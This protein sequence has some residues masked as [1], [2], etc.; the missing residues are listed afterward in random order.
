MSPGL[1]FRSGRRIAG[2][3]TA[4]ASVGLLF[5][6]LASGCR[7]DAP[8]VAAVT[9]PPPATKPA[10]ISFP[11]GECRSCH[12]DI[13]KS[14]SGSHHALAHRVI[15][16]KVDPEAVNPA[17]N[18]TING[19]E[20]QLDWQDGRPVFKEIR[21]GQ[22]A[23]P[24][25]ADFVLGH[26]PLRQYIVPAGGGRYQ[27]AELAFDPVKKDWFNVFG[28]ERRL[29]GGMGTLA[30]ARHELELDVRA[31]PHD[32]FQQALRRRNR[33]VCL[34]LARARCRLHAVSRPPHEGAP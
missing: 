1:S 5:A 20:Y 31:L 12:E 9:P 27:A 25:T 28:D 6:S 32:R 10:P 2:L 8:K 21:P 23:E 3:V 18:T 30:R 29:P 7:P 19:I 11:S 17:R 24:Y 33:H 16:P 26:T 4:V 34:H 14:W 15:D 13:F 22:P